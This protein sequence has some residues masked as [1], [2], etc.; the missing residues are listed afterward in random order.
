MYGHLPS[1]KYFPEILGMGQ[2]VFLKDIIF[3]F[4]KFYKREVKHKSSVFSVVFLL[5]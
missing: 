3:F 2:N 5:S 1:L 4:I